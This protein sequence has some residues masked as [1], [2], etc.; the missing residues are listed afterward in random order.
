MHGALLG[1]VTTF[2]VS[3][4]S[5]SRRSVSRLRRSRPTPNKVGDNP[6][7]FCPFEGS[8]TQSKQLPGLGAMGTALA[9][10]ISVTPS[11]IGN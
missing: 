11:G 10:E 3:A 1:S 6:R 8:Q 2:G 9:A 5:I 7:H 4:R